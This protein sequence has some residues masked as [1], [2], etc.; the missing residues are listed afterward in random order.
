M[1]QIEGRRRSRTAVEIVHLNIAW[2][3]DH[4]FHRNYGH[5]AFTI[6]LFFP[7]EILERKF[8]HP[9]TLLDEREEP[10]LRFFRG[11]FFFFFLALGII[12]SFSTP[13]HYPLSPYQIFPST[14]IENPPPSPL[15]PT[16]SHSPFL[17]FRSSSMLSPTASNNRHLSQHASRF[18]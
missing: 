1:S 6:Y 16:C 10:V 15:K 3:G 13:L 11:S 18:R 17:S 8:E 4:A 5:H 7:D 9:K 12:T 2:R 14:Y